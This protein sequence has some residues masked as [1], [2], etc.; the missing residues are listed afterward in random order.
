MK[1]KP[2]PALLG[3]MERVLKVKLRGS[4]IGQPLTMGPKKK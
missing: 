4:N 1:A 2:D 3:K